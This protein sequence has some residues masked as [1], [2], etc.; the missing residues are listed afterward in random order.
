MLLGFIGSA[1]GAMSVGQPEVTAPEPFAIISF[2]RSRTAVM[3]IE[4]ILS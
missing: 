2:E 1:P 3:G 4:A